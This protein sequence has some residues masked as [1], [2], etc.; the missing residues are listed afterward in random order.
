MATLALLLLLVGPAG[1]INYETARLER[2]L[3]AV[4]TAEKITL[5]G[6]LDE[7][8]WKQAAVATDFIQSE[9]HEGEPA[10][11]RTEVRLLYDTD[12]LYVGVFAYDSEPG[13]LIINE[14]RKDFNAAS[15]DSFELI[16]DTFRD[17]RNGY[18]FATNPAG[19]KWDAQMTNEGREVN[20][21]WDGVWSVKARVVEQGWIA[22]ISIPFKTLKFRRADGQTWGINFQRRL[23]RRNEDSFWSPIP[24]IY[25]LSRVSLAGRLEDLEGIKTGA[26]IR[27]KPYLVASLGRLASGKHASDADLGADAKY[28]LT[29]G[30]TWDFTYNTD[31]SQVEADE[32]Q[33]NLTRFTLFFPE[34][35]DFFLE[36]SGIFQFGVASDRGLLA[37]TSGSGSTTPGGGGRQNAVTNDMIF[38]FSRRIGLSEEGSVIPILGGTR[39]T[40]RAGAYEVGLLNIQQRASA[41]SN[42]TNFTVGRLRRNLLG[43]SD[44]GVMMVNKE[45]L[46]SSHFDRVVGA[47]AN[48]RFG[49]KLSINSYLAKASTPSGGGRDLAGRASFTYKDDFWDLRSS[50]THIQENFINEMGFVPRQGIRKY[51]GFVGTT[52]RPER[53]RG[54]IRSFFP[55]VQIEYVRDRQGR[56]ET[57]YVDYHFPI[58][59]QNGSFIEAGINPTLEFLS[60]PFLI[61]RERNISI[62]PGAY[63]FDEYFVIGRSDSSRRISGNGRWAVGRFFTG[64]KHTYALGGTVRFNHKL[65]TSFSSTHNNI[66]LPQGHFQTHLLGVRFD[67]SFSTIMFLNALVQYNSDARQWSSNIRFNLI[68]RPLSDLFLVYNERRDSLSGRLIDRAL[69]AKFT[70]MVAR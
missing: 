30:L 52:I 57:R 13:R 22:E 15:G 4:R 59:F 14:L 36:N 11:E 45:V 18:Q 33:I 62:P 38:F 56:L 48:L 42:G 58:N 23:R 50:Y 47:D 49:Q 70:Y 43:S 32:Q 31:F 35:R 55:H 37:G 20:V 21:N 63:S 64:T 2:R 40:G 10:T 24:R 3:K 28:A 46:H 1:T 61:Q 8:A 60:K 26:N 54:A 6:R 53:L 69:I 16:L 67:Y 27:V 44:I 25:G 65:N 39:L 5:D 19:A 29:P 17:E 41:Q 7:P 66:N 68:H 34:K 9:A 51:A 12:N